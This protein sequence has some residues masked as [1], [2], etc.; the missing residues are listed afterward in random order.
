ML[1]NSAETKLQLYL[2]DFG[3]AREDFLDPP[4]QP[5]TNVSFRGTAAYASLRSLKNIEQGWR[6]DLEGAFWVMIDLL[7]GGVPWR[8]IA[9][10][11]SKV[12]YADVCWLVSPAVPHSPIVHLVVDSFVRCC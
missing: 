12:G 2:V 9:V 5:L 6:D 4:K 8:K 7:L 11:K 1:G 3:L 10:G